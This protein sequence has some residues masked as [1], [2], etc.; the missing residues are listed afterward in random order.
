MQWPKQSD[1]VGMHKVF[2]NP[3]GNGDGTADLTWMQ[4]HLTTII[5][6][7]PM[8]YGTTPVKK[9]TVN[10]AIAEYYLAALVDVEKEYG[11]QVNATGLQHFDGCFNFRPKRAGHSL[12]M[13]AYA[14]AVDH[15]AAHNPFQ[16]KHGLML[17]RVVQI[18]KDHE[19]IWGGDWSEGSADPMH[20]QWPRVK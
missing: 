11:D 2:G 10:R 7:F 14:A 19:A 8:F 6:P 17:P 9:L 18:F 15:D 12:S 3:D 5:P 13:H 20:F 16:H 1:L 4:Q